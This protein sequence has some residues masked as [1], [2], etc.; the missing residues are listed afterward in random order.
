MMTRPIRAFS[1]RNR[2]ERV[3]RYAADLAPSINNIQEAGITSPAAIAVELNRLGIP[4]AAGLSD[5]RPAQVAWVLHQLRWQRAPYHGTVNS[6]ADEMA[7]KAVA[8]PQARTA[9]GQAGRAHADLRAAALAPVIA[10]IRESGITTPYAIAAALTARGIPTARGH[11]FWL[12]GQVR[13]ILNRLDRLSAGLSG[14]PWAAVRT[15]PRR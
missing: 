14:S 15:A 5:W 2:T 4:V 8:T 9:G 3:R 11:R 13:S 10:E 7:R 1:R 12:A 6:G